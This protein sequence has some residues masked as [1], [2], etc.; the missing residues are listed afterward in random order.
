MINPKHEHEHE[1]DHHY[2]HDNDNN[3]QQREQQGSAVTSTPAG[4]AMTSLAA[5]GA[6][7]NSVD[8]A[9]VK[10]RS[11]R[12]MMQFKARNADGTWMFGQRRTI[13]ED[14]SRW[15]VNPMSFQHGFIC[16]GDNSK[17]L[18]ERLVS[19]GQPKPN[20]AELPDLGFKWQEE[21][22]VGMR[23]LDGV[24][25]GV[26]VVFKTN[27]IGGAQ[28]VAELINAVRNRLNG[29]QHGDKV[30]PIVRLERDSYPHDQYGRTPTPQ[31]PIVDW[32]PLGGPAPTP[33]SP[34]PSPSPSPSQP[35]EQPR[36]RRIA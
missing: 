10:G 34:S 20:L 21:W 33:T 32:M 31:M 2:D 28:A 14:G 15:A 11:G 1:H 27:T 9:S 13:P 36:R 17:L 23:C 16:F 3:K 19:V 30:A 29:G 6:E 35:A 24:D 26:E 22:A 18:D 4:G 12:P 5:L 8:T 7:L 25:A